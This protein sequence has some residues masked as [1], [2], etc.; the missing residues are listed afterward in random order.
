MGQVD[1]LRNPSAARIQNDERSRAAVF[2]AGYQH[3]D[4][5]APEQVLLVSAPHLPEVAVLAT[6]RKMIEADAV[7][8]NMHQTS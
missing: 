7:R 8:N 3:L 4:L 6:A 5:I 1:I 2:E